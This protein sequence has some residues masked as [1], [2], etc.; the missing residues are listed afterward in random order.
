MSEEEKKETIPEEDKGVKEPVEEVKEEVVE[1][2]DANVSFIIVPA[3]FCY[4]A[5]IEA[6]EAGIPFIV[7]VTEHIPAH[8]QAKVYNYLKQQLR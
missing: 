2:E 1:K 7:C 5:I 3:R 8:D 6:A 4:A